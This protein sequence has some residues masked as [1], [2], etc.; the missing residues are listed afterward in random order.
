M[1]F[2]TK[3]NFIAGPNNPPCT[4]T[5]WGFQHIIIGVNGEIINNNNTGM[6]RNDDVIGTLPTDHENYTIFNGNRG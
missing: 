3:N 6:E 1:S 4:V 2:L 5:T